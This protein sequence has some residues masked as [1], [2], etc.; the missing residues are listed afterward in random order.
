VAVATLRRYL[1]VARFKAERDLRRRTVFQPVKVRKDPGNDELVAA[2]AA[3]RDVGPDY[4][5]E[6]HLCRF[7]RISFHGSRRKSV[8][9]P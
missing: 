4:R 5:L 7:G 6:V 3:V 8:K 9:L 1:R 2:I